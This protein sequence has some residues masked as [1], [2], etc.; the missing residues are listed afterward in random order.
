MRRCRQAGIVAEHP[1]GP[2]AVPRLAELLYD[3]L[4]RGRERFVL[5]VAIGNEGVIG[6][7]RASALARLSGGRKPGR[8]SRHGSGV[9]CRQFDHGLPDLRT[10]LHKIAGSTMIGCR[11]VSLR[12]SWTMFWVPPGP[13]P[14]SPFHRVMKEVLRRPCD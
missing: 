4:Q 12:T 6:D 8:T 14:G 11:P 13:S 2:P 7:R 3:R 1:Q 5:R 9:V 10:A